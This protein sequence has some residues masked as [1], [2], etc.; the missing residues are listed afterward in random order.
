MMSCR[1]QDSASRYHEKE[2]KKKPHH[3]QIYAGESSPRRSQLG[4]AGRLRRGRLV[5]PRQTEPQ[6][7]CIGRRQTRGDRETG[8]DMKVREFLGCSP[9]TSGRPKTVVSR[10]MEASRRP[11]AKLMKDERGRAGF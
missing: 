4:F 3:S 11:V 1:R 5:L 2:K 10:R 9:A 8:H 6:R 7:N